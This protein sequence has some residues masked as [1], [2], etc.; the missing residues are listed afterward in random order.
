[1]QL[2]VSENSRHFCERLE[3]GAAPVTT[4][5]PGARKGCLCLIKSKGH[6]YYSGGWETITAVNTACLRSES[7]EKYIYKNENLT[8]VAREKWSLLNEILHGI[9][10]STHGLFS[11]AHIT[12]MW[13]TWSHIASITSHTVGWQ[14]HQH[15]FPRASDLEFCSLCLVSV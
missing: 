14:A 12:S 15:S 10:G 4:A 1:M 11:R 3:S 6:Y 7:G 5:P 9:L 2:K 13:K 8:C